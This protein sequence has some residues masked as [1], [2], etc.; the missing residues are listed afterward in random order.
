[1]LIENFNYI[2]KEY[3]ILNR[4]QIFSKIKELKLQAYQKTGLN[5]FNH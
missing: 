4:Q 3:A 2:S 1:M 5:G